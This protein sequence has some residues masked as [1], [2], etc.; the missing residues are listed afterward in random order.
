VGFARV[1]ASPGG[2]YP[3]RVPGKVKY[4]SQ[5][6]GLLIRSRRYNVATKG[7]MIKRFLYNIPNIYSESSF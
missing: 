3:I 5:T 1:A 4:L 7:S 2:S 6:I